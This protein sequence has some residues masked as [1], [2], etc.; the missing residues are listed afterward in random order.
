VNFPKVKEHQKLRVGADVFKEDQRYLYMNVSDSEVL[1]DTA[2][3]D[4]EESNYASEHNEESTSF[5][6]QLANWLSDY[7]T[8]KVLA[9]D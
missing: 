4:S 7:N 2:T 9:A 6:E 1:R 3:V 8:V 5:S